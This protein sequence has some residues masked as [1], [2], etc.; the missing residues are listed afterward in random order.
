MSPDAQAHEKR[1][2]GRTDLLPSCTSHLVQKHPVWKTTQ[3]LGPR[4]VVE[5][6]ECFNEPHLWKATKRISSQTRWVAA[7]MPRGLGRR[8]AVAVQRGS[9]LD[10]LCKITEGQRANIGRLFCTVTEG[11]SLVRQLPM[12]PTSGGAVRHTLPVEE[13]CKKTTR[14]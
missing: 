12:F 8:S 14:D 9:S 5:A 13:R 11:P 6:Q 10:T 3:G 7:G 1:L 4:L 2:D